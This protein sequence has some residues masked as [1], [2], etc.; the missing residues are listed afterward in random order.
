MEKVE[1]AKNGGLRRNGNT[2]MWETEM[3]SKPTGWL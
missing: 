1:I 2:K 3:R